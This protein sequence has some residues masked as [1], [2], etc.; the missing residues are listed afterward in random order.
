MY[1]KL[2]TSPPPPPPGNGKIRYRTPSAADLSPASIPLA[3][4]DLEGRMKQRLSPAVRQESL[5]EKLH[6]YRGVVLIVSVP[7][8]LVSF[9]LLFMPRASGPIVIG[10]ATTAI[11][12]RKTIPGGGMVS[13]GGRRSKSYA[14]IFDAGSSGS[15]VHVY[16]F[17]E[18]LDL[19]HI[20]KELELFE[21]VC[22][23]LYALQFGIR[24]T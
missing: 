18:N 9:V 24:V 19:V 5:L 15:R 17:D 16:C 23:G 3:A 14:V 13:G 2:E 7:L 4:G 10:D 21:Q 1:S 11:A 8:L 12:G 20:G 22:P 6:R